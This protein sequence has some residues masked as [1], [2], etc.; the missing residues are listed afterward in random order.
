MDPHTGRVLAMVGG[1]SFEQ[2]EF[3]RAT[4]AKRQPGSAFK[5]F[6][7]AAALEQGF[8]PADQI[9]DAPFV[10]E[11]KDVE[12]EENELG[13]LALRGAQEER[14]EDDFIDDVEEDE[15]ERFYKPENY[16]A[17]NFYGLSTLRLG[18][19]C[20]NC[21]AFFIQVSK[22]LDKPRRRYKS[23]KSKRLSKIDCR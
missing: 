3:N 14:N 21:L 23:A 10:I 16:N 9:L 6:V 18:I 15:C 19:L 5:P 17:G 4:Q 13:A 22:C 8:T 20:N 1:Y 2:S 7:Y 11:R 12:C